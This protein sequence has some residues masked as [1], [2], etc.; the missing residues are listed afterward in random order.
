MEKLV[1]VHV[2]QDPL[3]DLENKRDIPQRLFKIL[4]SAASGDLQIPIG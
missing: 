1:F 2:L 3:P 4:S